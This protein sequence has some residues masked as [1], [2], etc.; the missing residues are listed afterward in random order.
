MYFISLPYLQLVV[1]ISYYN[2]PS[3]FSVS[4]VI[5]MYNTVILFS[6]FFF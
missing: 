1:R 4:Q 5:Y 6:F 2:K 3:I